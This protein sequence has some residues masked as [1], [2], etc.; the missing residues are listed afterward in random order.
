MDVN[1]TI[2]DALNRRGEYPVITV[3]DGAPPERVTITGVRAIDGRNT[4]QV[5]AELA[6]ATVAATAVGK[7]ALPTVARAIAAGLRARPERSQP[8]DVILAENV[9][10][11]AQVVRQ[12]IADEPAAGSEGG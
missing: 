9:R 8:L 6:T 7:A 4:D 1:T 11:A 2:V 10:V 5:A 3:Q 12:A